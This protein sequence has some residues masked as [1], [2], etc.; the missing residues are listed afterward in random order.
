MFAVGAAENRVTTI[1]L[2]EVFGR[3]MTDRRL[4]LTFVPSRFPQARAASFSPLGLS[5]TPWYP[6]LVGGL[7]DVGTIG[8]AKGMADVV[9]HLLSADVVLY[10]KTGTLNAPPHVRSVRRVDTIVVRG[11]ALARTTVVVDTVVPPV[12]AKTLVFAVGP[13]PGFGRRR[14]ADASPGAN[15]GSNAAG[16]DTG[17]SGMAASAAALQCGLVG[18]V[19]FRLRRNPP[20]VESLS[21]EFANER[22]WA[23]LRRNWDRLKVCRERG[24]RGE[25]LGTRD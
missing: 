3:I 5:N 15:G 14:T 8:T 11:S 24:V 4:A 21:T 6:A 22:L 17:G 1:D 7:R 18:T 12:V 25:G 13:P 23:V 20:Q 19:Y 9:A 16:V 10:G 2:T